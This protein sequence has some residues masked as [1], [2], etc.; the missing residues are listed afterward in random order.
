MLFD[1]SS[2]LTLRGAGTHE[3]NIAPTADATAVKLVYTSDEALYK[4]TFATGS[5][6]SR[7]LSWQ[8]Q[9]PEQGS[10]THTVVVPLSGF[11]ASLHGRDMPGRTLKAAELT[12]I[13]LN[14]SVFD[15]HGR[16]IAGREGGAFA[17]AL[18]SLEWVKA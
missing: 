15:M 17:I 7:G 12:S 2:R 11:K 18:H 3:A 1:C 4:L 13:G 14:S 8:Y 6:N 9:L 16:A 5:M 10:G